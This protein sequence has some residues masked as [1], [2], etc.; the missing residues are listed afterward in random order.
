MKIIMYIWQVPQHVLALLLV[1]VLRKKILRV[2]RYMHTT[3]YW[4]DQ[5]SWGVSLG[6]YIIL[7]ERFS[8]T[9]LEHEYGHSRQSQMLGPLYLLIVGLPS[10]T[11]NVL[12]RAYVLDPEDYYTRWPENWA[13]KLGGVDRSRL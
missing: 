13:D 7:D 12:T 1:F 8:R 2:G 11:M 10:I 9:T 6:R 4:V 5:T 3:V